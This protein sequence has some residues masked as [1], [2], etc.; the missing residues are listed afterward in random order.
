MRVLF[1]SLLAILLSSSFIQAQENQP[2]KLVQFTGMVLDGTDEALFPVTYANIYLKNR[3]RGTYSDN[4]GYF[5]I[6]VEEG[7][8]VLFSTIGYKTAEFIIPDTLEEDRYSIVQLMTRDTF[9]LPETVVFPWPSREHFKIEFLAMDVSDAL[10]ERAVENLAEEALRR[11]Q[12]EVM[13]D[14][15]EQADY[16]LRQQAKSYYHI[17]QTPP[18]NIFNVMAWKDFFEAWKRGDFKKKDKK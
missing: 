1:L 9:N 10:A 11:Q 14:G 2:R 17:G 8:T 13:R 18:M 12:N 15:D 7:D 5:T 6:V 16:Y 3:S 4:Q